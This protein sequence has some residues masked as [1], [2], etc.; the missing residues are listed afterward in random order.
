MMRR[1][2]ISMIAA[3]ALGVIAPSAMAQSGS[4]ATAAAYPNKPIRF[5]VGFPPGGVADIVARIIARPLSQ[6]LGQPVVM[7]NRAG[8]GGVVGV[9]AVA[10]STP[11]GHTMGFGVSGALT[12]NVTLMPKLPYDPLKDLALVTKVVNNPIVLVVNPSLGINSVQDFIAFAKSKRGAVSYGTAGPGTAMHLAGE[13]FKQKT[14]VEM[15]HIGYKGSSPAAVDVIAGQIQAGILDLVTA[16]PYIASGHLKALGVTT[17]KRSAVAPELP[18][19]AE[20]GVPGFEFASW[21]GL[22]MPGATPPDIVARVGSEVSA[23]LKDPKV[24]EQLL[25]AGAEPE[26]G[27]PEEMRNTVRK[28]IQDTRALIKAASI[29]VN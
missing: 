5:V 17:A 12:A 18:T 21:F 27:T 24:R 14:G 26:P 11:D 3:A 29:T 25:A 16:K 22:V 1:H 20:G 2:F 6:R 8:A 9:E 28:E 15:T 7:D 4:A 23:V 13:L 19:I 10:N